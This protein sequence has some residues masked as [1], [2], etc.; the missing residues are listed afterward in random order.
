[1]GTH[2][3]RQM[4]KILSAALAGTLLVTAAAPAM[5]APRGSYS[6]GYYNR[7]DNTGAMI[8]LGIGLFAL[9]AIIASQPRTE[10][11]YGPRYEPRY[12]PP[13][14]PPRYRYD[15]RYGNDRYGYD[16]YYYGR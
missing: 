8:G 3:R 5:A 16:E 2:W 4:K 6:R 15:D 9:G 12:V 13:P 11:Y 1:M 10:V 14:P 7:R